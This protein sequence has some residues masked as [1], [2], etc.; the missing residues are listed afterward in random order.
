[1][2]KK[3]GYFIAV[4]TVVILFLHG[5]FALNMLFKAPPEKEQE[6]LNI[7]IETLDNGESCKKVGLQ[8]LESWHFFK[9]IKVFHKALVYDPND[10]EAYNYLGR[11]YYMTSDNEKA[12]MFLKIAISIKS[13]YADAYYNL[14]DVY[15]REG[16]VGMAMQQYKTAIDINDAFRNRKRNFFGEDFVPL[17]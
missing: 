1:M 13:D 7:D 16:S 2:I 6:Y 9:A 3:A 11:A 14:G 5:C 8:L 10:A 12:K 4:F 17:E 15:L